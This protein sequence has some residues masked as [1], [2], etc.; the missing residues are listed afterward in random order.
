MRVRLL[1][2]Q[3]PGGL[4]RSGFALATS[5]P[6]GAAP[7]LSPLPFPVP[8]AGSLAAQPELDFACASLLN[9]LTLYVR[10][11]ILEYSQGWMR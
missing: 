4:W 9:G 10:K 5:A 6:G 11:H 3:R 1:L 2:P 8:P 7:T